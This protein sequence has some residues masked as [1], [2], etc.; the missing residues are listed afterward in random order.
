MLDLE[1]L[2]VFALIRKGQSSDEPKE[3]M[4]YFGVPKVEVHLL[5]YFYFF[6]CSIMTCHKNKHNASK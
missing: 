6:G 3:Q 2:S 4:F 5:F 1:E